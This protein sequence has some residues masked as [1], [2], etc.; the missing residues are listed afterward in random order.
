M[1]VKHASEIRDEL[2]FEGAQNGPYCSMLVIGDL[3]FESNILY[4]LEF[5]KC[6]IKG[7]VK[8]SKCIFKEE[9]SFIDINFEGNI[10]FDNVN[11]EK[12]VNFDGCKLG[13]F[14]VAYINKSPNKFKIDRSIFKDDANLSSSFYMDVFFNSVIFEKYADF[15]GAKFALFMASLNCVFSKHVGFMFSIFEGNVIIDSKFLVGASFENAQFGK[16]IG[17]EYLFIRI[18]RSLLRGWS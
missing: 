12:E 4:K 14:S 1:I 13:L 3:I 17:L 10:L 16:D 15:H 9:L 18:S 6:T 8:F 7:D 5:N 2:D 11:F